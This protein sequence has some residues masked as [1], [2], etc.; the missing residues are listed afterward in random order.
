MKIAVEHKGGELSFDCGEREAI[1]YAGLRQGVNLPFEC[2]TGT[3]GTCRARIMSGEV[4]VRWK[5]APGGARLKPLKG[6]ILMCQSWP[7]SDIAMR[8]PSDLTTTDTFKPALRR[9]VIRNIERLTTDVAQFDLQLSGS[10]RFQPG[11]FVVLESPDV[12]GGR[13]YSMVN[14]EPE[15]DRLALLLKRKP[16]GGFTD[17]FFDRIAGEPE[18]DVFGPLGRAVFRPEERRNIVC[19]AGGSGIAGMMSILECAI[20]A[21]HFSAHK[22]AVFFGCRTLADTFYLEQLSRYAAASHGNLEITVALSHEAVAA[23]LHGDFPILRLAQ[24]MVHEVAAKRLGE[25]DSNF[26]AY[27]AGPPIMVDSTIR[28]LI[29]GGVAVRDIR[30]DKFA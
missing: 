13:A 16:G 5:E 25:R 24:G 21:D 9:G 19:V 15:L 1:L 29:T 22:G 11:Q 20:Q 27:V 7:R 10:M 6:D 14:F 3:C 30:Y 28:T 18:L 12:P 23:P 4:E 8:V 2:A 26:L 17:W